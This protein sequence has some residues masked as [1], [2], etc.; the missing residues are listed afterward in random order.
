M[1]DADHAPRPIGITL[2]SLLIPA[3]FLADCG[4]FFF[5]EVH[6]SFRTDPSFLRTAA[7]SLAFTLILRSASVLAVF[8][9][10]KGREWALWFV[11]LSSAFTLIISSFFLLVQHTRGPDPALTAAHGLLALFLFVYLNTRAVRAWFR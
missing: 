1:T 4:M 10:W 3:V 11:M 6:H 2:A 7:V 5:D 9:F 8:F